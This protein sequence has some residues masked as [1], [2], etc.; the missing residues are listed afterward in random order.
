MSERVRVDLVLPVYNEERDLA[1]SVLRLRRFLG[2][3]FGAYDWRIL[4]A[5]NASSDTTSE[6][7]RILSDQFTDVQYLRFE[8]RGR[9]RA[10]RY[11]WQAST[12]DI[13]CYM[14][15]DLSTDLHALVPL[16]RSLTVDG[17]DVATGSRLMPGSRV[18]RSLKR[19]VLSRG[20][21]LLLKWWLQV[22]FDDA[23]CGFKAMRRRV[24]EPVLAQVRDEAW[25]FD[26]ELLIKARWMG[27]RIIS[28]PVRWVEDPESRVKLWETSW[29]YLCSISRL[30]RERASQH[31]PRR[32]LVEAVC[33][34]PSVSDAIRSLLAGG[35]IPIKH[36]VRCALS[37]APQQ[38]VLD[39]G[40]GSGM[41]SEVVKG[42]YLGIDTDQRFLDHATQRYGDGHRVRFAYQP[43]TALP[44]P[45]QSYDQTLLV[46]VMHHLD[47]EALHR[48]LSELER[49]T[50]HQ[51]VIV[52]M[53]PLRYNLL[54]MVCYRMD[55]GKHIRSLAEQH[56][57]V[58][59][60]L[61]LT[62]AGYFRSGINLHSVFVGAPRRG[63]PVP[64]AR[65]RVLRI[66]TRMN[67]GGPSVHA[68]LLST[69]LDPQQYATSLVVGEPEAGEGDVSGLVQ[70]QGAR[71]H[72]LTTL[73]RPLHP[74]RDVLAFWQL[75]RIM[76]TERP[77]I[78]HTHLAK[79]GTLGRLAGL[80]YNRSE[81]HTSELQ[82]Q[83]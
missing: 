47:D 30:R 77:N 78:I 49:V 63:A 9:G 76:W 82:S 72:R 15:V 37:R 32:G 80:L 45:D 41:I 70:E 39:V 17:Y 64:P 10:L 48:V 26:S 36:T 38:R 19:E 7:G 12:A 59:R 71:V 33:S 25:F 21:N 61:R 20:Y 8:E 5:D 62:E 66:L 16:I 52:D 60:H 50:A 27:L 18:T 51:I 58:I 75:L 6:I 4:I 29:N 34:N 65:T 13:V 56:A 54:G 68:A 73:R 28:I 11:A 53:A 67:I 40:C 46:N 79:A 31:V 57:R 83:R 23:Q 55:Q 35:L 44:Y 14:D 2:E 69:K 3:Q 42:E 74:W 81:E 22:E 1:R 24:V 43:A